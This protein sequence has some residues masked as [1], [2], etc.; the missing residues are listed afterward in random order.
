MCSKTSPPQRFLKQL[1]TIA[2]L[3]AA[4]GATTRASALRTAA[5]LTTIVVSDVE[6]LYTAV[7]NPANTGAVIVL[8]PGVYALS[9]TDPNGILRPNGGRLDLQLD[10]SLV[11]VDGDR[12]AVTIDPAALPRSSFSFPPVGLTGI[13]RIGRGNNTIEWITV[14]G[15]PGAA[16]AISTDV[17]QMDAFGAAVATSVRVAHV[18]AAGSIRGVDVRNSTVGMRGRRMVAEIVDNDFYWS[19]EGVRVANFTGADY[20]EVSVHMLNNH[21]HQNR[22]GCIVENNR[23]SYATISIQSEGDVFDDNGLACLIGGALVFSGTA[24]FSTT[25]IDAYSSLFTNNTR[26][27]FNPAVKGPEFDSG[28]LVV[29][30]AEVGAGT[31]PYSTSGN[32]V[33]VSLWDCQVAGNHLDGRV[34]SNFE[35]FGARSQVAVS[36]ALTVTNNHALVQLR[37]STAAVDIIAIDRA[38]ADLD[39]TNSVTVVRIP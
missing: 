34:D 2:V 33:N 13:I 22:V 37:G 29:V 25:R 9:A 27:V 16:A 4:L 19:H 6:Q 21:S 15:N 32:T 18:S 10:M 8:S 36:D 1:L 24:N 38:P 26:T 14:T 3:A 11:G 28:G 17:F 39:V 7:N 20:A 12:G 35:A 23:A 31:P 30:G 5:N